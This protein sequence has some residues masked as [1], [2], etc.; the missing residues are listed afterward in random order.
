MQISH[1]VLANKNS[2][3]RQKTC[4]TPIFRPILTLF[5][6]LQKKTSCKMWYEIFLFFKKMS[7]SINLAKTAVV[8]FEYLAPIINY[9]A[10]KLD[11]FY[12][13]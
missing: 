11:D 1:A 13:P 8:L 10:Q 3:I 9:E 7:I 5:V 2:R 4:L 12:N 6:T